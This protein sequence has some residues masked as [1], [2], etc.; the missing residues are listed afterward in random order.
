MKYKEV[1]IKRQAQ[2]KRYIIKRFMTESELG[3]F[4][5]NYQESKMI[6]VGR[7]FLKNK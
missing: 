1:I 6:S 5:K 2:Y 3:A 4:E 7:R